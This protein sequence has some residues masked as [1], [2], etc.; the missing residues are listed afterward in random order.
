[1]LHSAQ[2]AYVAPHSTLEPRVSLNPRQEIQEKLFNC[3]HV[4]LCFPVLDL[5]QHKC[6]RFG[7]RILVPIVS[8]PSLLYGQTRKGASRWPSRLQSSHVI[9]RILFWSQKSQK[10]IKVAN[11]IIPKVSL[12]GPRLS[13]ASLINFYL[14]HWKLGNRNNG[15]ANVMYSSSF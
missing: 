12:S 5:L 9:S 2:G 13:C 6:H 15:L 4:S 3:F 8:N 14:H 10:N 1:M 7:V 11:E